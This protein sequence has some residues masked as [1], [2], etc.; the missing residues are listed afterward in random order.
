MNKKMKF[1]LIAC[2]ATCAL[3]IASLASCGSGNNSQTSDE[4]T[5]ESTKKECTHEWEEGSIKKEAGCDYSGI[6]ILECSLCDETKEEEIPAK[7][8]DL[9]ANFVCSKCDFTGSNVRF[10]PS[11]STFTVSGTNYDYEQLYIS[12]TKGTSK[13][14]SIKEEAF[15]GNTKVKELYLGE[16]IY[17]IGKSA[18]EG[19]TSLEKIVLP[20][21]VQ[22]ISASAFKGCI[23]L[24]SVTFS[25][26]AETDKNTN[27]LG[28]NIE[29]EAFSGCN[30][31]EDVKLSKNILN[32]TPSAF[33]ESTK[34]LTLENGVYYL[35]EW[36]IR[37]AKDVTEITF[38]EGTKKFPRGFVEAEDKSVVLPAGMDISGFGKL[39]DLY[40]PAT[41]EHLTLPSDAVELPDMKLAGI[42]ELVIPET[43]T[44]IGDIVCASIVELN[45]P[46]S[47]KTVGKIYNCDNLIKINVGS[48]VEKMWKPQAGDIYTPK[49]DGCG[50]LAEVFSKSA[51][52]DRSYFPSNINFYTPTSGQS[53]LDF[54]TVKDYVFMT[55][56]EDK[57]LVKYLGSES[58]ITL[59]S[60]YKGEAYK[61]YKSAFAKNNTLTKVTISEGVTEIGESAFSA[62]ENIVT[63]DIPASVAK[64]AKFAFSGCAKLENVNF[65]VGTNLTSIGESAF[66]YCKSLKKFVMPGSVLS[67][68]QSL[69]ADCSKLETV[70][71]SNKLRAI[72]DSM[73]HSCTAL[74]NLVIPDSVRSIGWNAF[75]RCF[76]RVYHAQMEA[77]FNAR[78]TV[79]DKAGISVDRICFC[80]TQDGPTGIIGARGWYYDEKGEPKAWPND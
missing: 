7:G 56:G 2:L 51:V 64:I 12:S 16:G 31:L 50:S 53:T 67:V 10:E 60:N 8:H 75:Y 5:E 17:R 21:T 39:I 57:Y 33:D 52:I 72:P 47:V 20:S 23:A 1:G 14:E 15:K 38:R 25:E 26:P 70:K 11:G 42:K 44:V 34:A 32:I 58:E 59:P 4:D 22:T 35:G 69:F 40:F 13:A 71:L 78:V 80:L 6:R 43:V 46:D 24:K 41:L 65:T 9:D 18:F 73:F 77:W 54:T 76:G 37:Q 28:C 3:L 63:V 29:A 19:C 62:S 74:S 27:T 66:E 79:D 49:C 61:I 30:A 45:I 68:G 36:A 55:V 48:G